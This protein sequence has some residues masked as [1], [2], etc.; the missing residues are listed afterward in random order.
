MVQENA[1]LSATDTARMIRRDGSPIC[2]RLVAATSEGEFV[3]MGCHD[4]T[5]DSVSIHSR[6]AGYSADQMMTCTEGLVL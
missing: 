2:C 4:C 3:A 1:Q 6:L 5:V